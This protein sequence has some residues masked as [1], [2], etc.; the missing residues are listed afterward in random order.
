MDILETGAK[1]TRRLPWQEPSR[2]VK[3]ARVE[4]RLG[5]AWQGVWGVREG[6]ESVL[7]IVHRG[8]KAKVTGV[9]RGGEDLLVQAWR[10]VQ[11]GS[12]IV[13]QGLRRP[14]RWVARLPVTRLVV[15]VA[16]GSTRWVAKRPTARL[17]VKVAKD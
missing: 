7:M 16:Q 12:R 9:R 13:H 3:G 15:K 2:A 1:K 14:T 4:Q 11:Q 6:F 8:M 17:V 5:S 10:M